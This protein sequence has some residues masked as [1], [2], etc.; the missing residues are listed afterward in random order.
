MKVC[1]CTSFMLSTDGITSRRLEKGDAVDIPDHMAKGLIFEGYVKEYVGPKEDKA[2]GA[3]PENKALFAAEENK[4][5]DGAPR[6]G[7]GRPR[8]AEA[9]AE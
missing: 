9:A 1:A 6:R 5:D 8:K 4:D 7:P 3:A 2:I